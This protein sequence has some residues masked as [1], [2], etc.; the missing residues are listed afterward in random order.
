MVLFKLVW[1]TLKFFVFGEG[2]L[3]V[4]AGKNLALAGTAIFYHHGTLA[5]AAIAVTLPMVFLAGDGLWYGGLYAIKKPKVRAWLLAFVP[6]RGLALV[7]TLTRLG[8][9]AHA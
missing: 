1:N 7:S 9:K 3:V 6:A 2:G 5:E 4:F 8:R